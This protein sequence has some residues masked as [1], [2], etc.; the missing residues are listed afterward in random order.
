MKF[1]NKIIAFQDIKLDST[2][3]VTR[4]N[5]AYWKRDGVRDIFTHVYAPDFPA[6]EKAYKAAGKEVF[7][8]E[9]SVSQKPVETEEKVAQKPVNTIEEVPQKPVETE[10]GKADWTELGW[11]EMRSLATKYTDEPVK[12]KSQAKE[13][14]EQAEKDGLL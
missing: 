1:E 7:R 5:P 6:I 11:V 4:S 14:L 12:N 3:T 10:E 2:W 8:P 13:V 9:G